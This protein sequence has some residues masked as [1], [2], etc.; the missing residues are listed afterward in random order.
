MSLVSC[1]TLSIGKV[2]S[3]SL[4]HKKTIYPS[5]QLF[6]LITSLYIIVILKL[7]MKVM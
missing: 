2:L 7:L 6:R 5:L 1:P 3:Y 4:Q